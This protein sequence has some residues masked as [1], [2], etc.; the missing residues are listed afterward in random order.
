MAEARQH[1]PTPQEMALRELHSAALDL[2]ET[3]CD[4]LDEMLRDPE[5]PVEL[6]ASTAVDYLARVAPQLD[7]TALLERIRARRTAQLE[8]AAREADAEARA[9]QA[10]LRKERG[11]L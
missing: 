4:V 6:R 2:T 8:A 1:H 11:P 5:T 3:A 7:P 9:D 10:A